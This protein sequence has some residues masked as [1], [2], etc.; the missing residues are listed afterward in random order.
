MACQFYMYAGLGNS[1]VFTFDGQ[2]DALLALLA[3]DL[4][5][6]AYGRCV[7]PVGTVHDP[8][9]SRLLYGECKSKQNIRKHKKY[10]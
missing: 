7:S 6:C 3:L 10:S 2:P 5:N 4:G 9:R 1:P 8:G